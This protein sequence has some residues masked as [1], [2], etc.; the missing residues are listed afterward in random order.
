MK[1]RRTTA[2]VLLVCIALC[3][4]GILWLRP[5]PIAKHLDESLM[6]EDVYCTIH[7]VTQ[8]DSTAQ[9][10]Q[11][12]RQNLSKLWQEVRVIG[13]LPAK[14]AAVDAEEVHLYLAAPTAQEDPLRETVQIFREDDVYFLNIGSFGYR[15]VSGQDTLDTFM[16]PA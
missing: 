1:R 14:R 4:C 10:D 11:P 2:I 13:P 8:N 15:V 3:I 5:K 16:S 9:L 6:Q 7:Y 12:L